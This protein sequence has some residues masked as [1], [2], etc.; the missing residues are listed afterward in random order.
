LQA[1][2]LEKLRDLQK[3]SRMVADIRKISDEVHSLEIH[4]KYAKIDKNKVVSY[5]TGTINE[6]NV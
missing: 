6:Q 5:G 1:E 2:L 3:Q 4:V